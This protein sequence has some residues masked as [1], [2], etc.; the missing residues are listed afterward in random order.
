MRNCI[1][2][3]EEP[4]ENGH[5]VHISPGLEFDIHSHRYACEVEDVYPDD[6][7]DGYSYTVR[8]VV[9]ER[10][11]PQRYAHHDLI[12]SPRGYQN[13]DA[14]LGDQPVHGEELL[15][16]L[17]RPD[18]ERINTCLTVVDPNK[19]PT[20][21]WL[22]ELMKNDVDRINSVAAELILLYH[23]RTTFGRER[24]SLNA[25]IDGKESKDF[26]I[27]VSTDQEDVWIEIVKPDYAASIGE[28]VGFISR[29]TTGNSIDRKLKQ[30]FEDGRD[31]LPEDTVLVLATYLEEQITQGW[32]IEQWMDEDYYGVS[33][34]CDAWLTY[35][36]LMETEMQYHSFTE[37]GERC[38]TIF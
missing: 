5:I 2:S 9:Q 30:K 1:V 10:I 31:N 14:L 13:I 4:L 24:V 6:N 20:K 7:V 26:D 35:T 11:L 15:G 37:D 23:L 25:H 33:E 38:R 17:K 8:S 18:L 28:E 27:R 3:A 29:D 21:D 12:P 34:F 19:D 16:K 32:Q 22:N 36:H